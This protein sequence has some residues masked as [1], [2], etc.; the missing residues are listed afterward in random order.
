M[1]ENSMGSAYVGTSRD[2]TETSSIDPRK[3]WLEEVDNRYTFVWDL[4]ENITAMRNR[5]GKLPKGCACKKNLCITRQCG[6]KQKGLTCG[7]R[8]RCINCK[9]VLPPPS[10]NESS[11]MEEPEQSLHFLS[12]TEQPLL[13]G[14]EIEL[15]HECGKA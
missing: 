6:C 15:G 14:E 2:Y 7:P 5:A 10:P 11:P 8:C 1:A 4:D 13:I 3:A 12:E 9:N